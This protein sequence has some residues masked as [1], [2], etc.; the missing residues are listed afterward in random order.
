[1]SSRMT[2]T[3][4]KLYL[5]RIRD[6]YGEE[7][8]DLQ[9][10]L[11]ARGGVSRMR[12]I[13]DMLAA[14]LLVRRVPPAVLTIGVLFVIGGLATAGTI[15]SGRGTGTPARASHCQ[16]RLGVQ[17]RRPIPTTHVRSPVARRAR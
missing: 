5:R 14:A 2:R 8:L 11:Q 13:G 3:L 17:A 7:L 4:L 10:Q 12:L 16:V 1:M 9:D 6:R 15:I